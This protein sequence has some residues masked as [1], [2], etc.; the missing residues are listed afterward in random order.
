MRNYKIKRQTKFTTEQ[1]I[2]VYNAVLAGEKDKDIA[3][4]IGMKGIDVSN[5]KFSM[6]RY[7]KQPVLNASLSQSYREAVAHFKGS[8]TEAKKEESIHEVAAVEPK[9]VTE[10]APSAL[11]NLESALGGL[12]DKIAAVI[13]SEVETRTKEKITEKEAELKAQKEKY[14]Q[15]LLKLQAIIAS[16][17]SSSVTGLIQKAWNG[18]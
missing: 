4:R 12:N 8:T 5:I 9:A 10:A 14:E 3:L 16:M 1:I 18:R 17:K 15:E 11:Q 6:N 2:R 7:M 13:L